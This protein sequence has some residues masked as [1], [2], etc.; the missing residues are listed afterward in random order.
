M[1]QGHP[2]DRKATADYVRSLRS[3]RWSNFNADIF[4]AGR[5][6]LARLTAARKTMRAIEAECQ[7]GRIV[8]L[9]DQFA[10][11]FQLEQ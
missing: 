11:V 8:K 3:I 5:N 9:A 10:S 7:D 6:R 2:D 4:I 1:K